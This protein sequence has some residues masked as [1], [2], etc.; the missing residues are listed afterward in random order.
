MQSHQI[1]GMVLIVAGVLDAAA[2]MWVPSRIPDEGQRAIVR[3][4]LLSSGVVVVALGGLFFAGV[5]GK[6]S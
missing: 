2:A 6:S 5:I 3:L 1:V 4:A